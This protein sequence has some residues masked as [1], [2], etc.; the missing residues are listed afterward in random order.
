MD[1]GKPETPFKVIKLERDLTKLQKY[2]VEK[3]NENKQLII[4]VLPNREINAYS[5]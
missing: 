1:I 2:F 3:K 5:K 4:V